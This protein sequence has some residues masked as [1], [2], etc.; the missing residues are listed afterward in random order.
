MSPKE[1]TNLTGSFFSI[2]INL[3][4]QKELVK[5]KTLRFSIKITHSLEWRISPY[6]FLHKTIFNCRFF[7]KKYAKD[8]FCVL[9]NLLNLHQFSFHFAIVRILLHHPI[10]IYVNPHVKVTGSLSVCTER[11]RWLSQRNHT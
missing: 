5:G 7:I 8:D 4:I 2:S 1:N 6:F 3:T 10:K 9:L 11:S